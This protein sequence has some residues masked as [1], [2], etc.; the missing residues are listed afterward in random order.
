[1][2]RQQCMRF[3]R[4]SEKIKTD[5]SECDR[6]VMLQTEHKNRARRKVA[7][8]TL[9]IAALF[10]AALRYFTENIWRNSEGNTTDGENA[11]LSKQS[12]P[13]EVNRLI[14][15][16]DAVRWVRESTCM[17]PATQHRTIW[18]HKEST[19]RYCIKLR[20]AKTY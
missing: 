1:M 12:S 19:G 15:G 17:H 4:E 16:A 18:Q 2:C 10:G 3:V 9:I 20:S 8:S 11:K 7:A 5:M 6:M 13:N 14:H